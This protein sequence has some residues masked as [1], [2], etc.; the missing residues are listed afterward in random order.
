MYLKEDKI[1]H[2]DKI[3]TYYRIVEAYRD[4]NGKPKQKVLFNL[5]K[6]SE[7]D[8]EKVKNVISLTDND[9]V[10]L[11]KTTDIIV[12]RHWLFLPIVVL[13]SIWQI[14]KLDHLFSSPLLVEAMVINRCIEPKS[15]IR[16]TDWV[17]KTAL[18]ALHKCD[19]LPGEYA[20]Y[21][22]QELSA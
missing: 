10:I 5:G 14:F 11:A 12:K 22:E 18:P 13:H 9:N 6:L 19:T 15:K 16:I 21:P 8:A 17:S 2:D 1:K 3:Y 7:E 4:T 20:V